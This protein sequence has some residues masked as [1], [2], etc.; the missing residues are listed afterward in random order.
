MSQE[1]HLI[2]KFLN[3]AGAV[4]Q[5]GVDRGENAVSDVGNIQKCIEAAEEAAEEEVGAA[6]EIT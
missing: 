1:S 6:E 3:F 2:S 5:C 4:P